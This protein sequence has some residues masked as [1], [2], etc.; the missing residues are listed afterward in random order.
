MIKKISMVLGIVVAFFVVI[1][2]L[3]KYDQIKADAAE[4]KVTKD[5]IQLVAAR[6]DQKIVNDNIRYIQQ[7][8]WDIQMY[9]QKM[10]QLIPPEVQ[11]QINKMEYDIKMLMQQLGK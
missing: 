10:G 8:I 6:L 2:G 1:G 9:Y 7:R 11:Q 4:L 3:W 5:Q